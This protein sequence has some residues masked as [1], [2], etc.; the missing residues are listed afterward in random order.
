M[1][2]LFEP[3]PA[4]GPVGK[5]PANK[6]KPETRGAAPKQAAS[7]PTV[8]ARV[9]AGKLVEEVRREIRD[10][11]YV[12]PNAA[13]FRQLCQAVQESLPTCKR[14]AILEYF[15]ET[16]ETEYYFV[17]LVRTD[18]ESFVV[19]NRLSWADECLPSWEMDNRRGK[20]R[21][22]QAEPAKADRFFQ[23]IDQSP[24]PSMILCERA[25][26]Q[27]EAILHSY[28]MSGSV[29]GPWPSRHYVFMDEQAFH[30]LRGYAPVGELVGDGEVE[31]I[32]RRGRT[33]PK[34]DSKDVA[35]GPGK[36]HR[37]DRI[38][39]RFGHLGLLFWD[40]AMGMPNVQRV[41]GLE[42]AIRILRRTRYVA[43]AA[44]GDAGVEGRF[45][46][47][48][49]GL[50]RTGTRK[51]FDRLLADEDARVRAMGL[52]CIA[53]TE[54][55]SRAGI[56]R[57]RLGEPQ[58]FGLLVSCIGRSAS[59]GEFA[60][61]LLH[62]TKFMESPWREEPAL[63]PRELLALDIEVL[64][65]DECAASHRFAGAGIAGAV[66]GG[67]CPLELTELQK[68]CP[69]L[70]PMAIIKAIGRVV[71]VRH[72]RYWLFRTDDEREEDRFAEICSF[73]IACL[74]DRRLP[75]DCRLAAGSALTRNVHKAGAAA[76]AAEKESLDKLSGKA[77]LGS[78]LWQTLR[79]RQAY[80]E[81]LRKLDEAT[82]DM[83]V[84]MAW[85]KLSPQDVA[86]LRK[87]APL[88]LRALSLRTLPALLVPLDVFRLTEACP[89]VAE[90]ADRTTL[91]LCGQF[92]RYDQP[93]NTYS[94]RAWEMDFILR[95]GVPEA[96]SPPS[97][98][99][100]DSFFDE[101]DEPPFWGQDDPRDPKEIAA[102]KAR[103]QE[104]KR[105]RQRQRERE[106]ARKLA[107]YK[108]ALQHHRALQKT[109][110]AYL[111]TRKENIP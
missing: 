110:R 60:L 99:E 13:G 108:K 74:K 107:A 17:L 96:P 14:V 82:R 61:A 1:L 67:K 52:Y 9:A 93:W 47:L 75:L 46:T 58:T 2:Y 89:E 65:R 48:G 29:Y 23:A 92:R 59:E 95:S 34:G 103:A 28:D 32:L 8:S 62:N 54:P 51:D 88:A 19:T 53:Q 104:R 87:V 101:D 10:R 84:A 18:R 36:H 30:V 71:P 16:P 6:G 64:W 3:Q 21:R 33:D 25:S 80:Y 102:G 31:A 55:D 41:G 39:D 98:E 68:L 97:Q 100:E 5:D 56:L 11:L 81:A 45:W 72:D 35:L 7:R 73:L 49:R 15:H 79:E 94:S 44:V 109:V 42:G 20:V 85:Q 63:G 37:Y 50:L 106:H 66:K 43:T 4:V 38:R 69:K 77:R 40:A 78:R 90:A 111:L 26:G 27:P 12:R 76:L 91:K 24:L 83:D 57:A 22:Y 70:A 86:S 105:Q